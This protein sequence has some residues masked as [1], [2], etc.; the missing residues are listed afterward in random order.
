MSVIPMLPDPGADTIDISVTSL[1]ISGYVGPGI[2]VTEVVFDNVSAFKVETNGT[3]T[4]QREGRPVCLVP[5]SITVTGTGS[6]PV[7]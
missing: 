1:T 6:G 5:T 7:F 3:I 2:P 4:F